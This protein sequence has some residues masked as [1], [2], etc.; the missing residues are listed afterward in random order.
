MQF[1][2]ERSSRGIHKLCGETNQM[3]GEGIIA[4]REAKLDCMTTLTKSAI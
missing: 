4:Q 2:G 1:M 3:M